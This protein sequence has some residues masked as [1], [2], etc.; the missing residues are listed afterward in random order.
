M[1]RAAE[2]GRTVDFTIRE[3]LESAMGAAVCE[4]GAGVCV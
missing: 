4:A 2:T 1:G 3:L